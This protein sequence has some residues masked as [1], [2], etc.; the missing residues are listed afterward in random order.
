M[1]ERSFFEKLNRFDERYAPA[2]YEDTDLC[3]SVR[4]AGK[5]VLYQPH[6]IVTHFE[7]VSSG[8]EEDKGIKRFQAIN[9]ESFFE[10]WKD[11]LSDHMPNGVN[12]HIASDPMPQGH[13][14]IVD[15]C[16]PTPDQDSG[17]I[18]MLN[19]IRIVTDLG[20][21]VHFIPYTNFA[22]FGDYT[23]NLQQMGVECIYAPHYRSCDE[24]LREN[25]A[26]FDHVLISRV[27]VADEVMDLVRQRCYGAKIIFY[28]VDLHFLR[29]LRE[30]GLTGDAA[31]AAKARETERKELALMDRADV[32]IVLSEVEQEQLRKRGKSNI[33]VIPLIR[34][35]PKAS[36][37][38][39]E[40]RSGVLFIGGYQH[41]PNIDAVDWL[42]NDIWP[43]VRKLAANNKIAPIPLRL[44][45]SKMPERFRDYACDDIKVHGY[46]GDLT[47]TFAHIRLSVAP[48]RYGAG[49]KGKIATSYEHG[50]PV[51]GTS[52][53]FEGIK[54]EGLDRASYC[55]DS[56]AGIARAIVALYQDPAQWARHSR[57]ARAYAESH[58]SMD[59]ATKRLAAL[60]NSK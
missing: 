22:H 13:I 23:K 16:T 28:T 15:A 24:Y 4:E 12:P 55:A 7:G 45:G 37:N 38:A 19:L 48:L 1:I 21:R 39:F 17:S 52:I 5:R 58:Y 2:Y 60:L 14:L 32:T 51:I 18:D 8:L 50:V 41:T 44:Y 11:R 35:I 26:L 3:F 6:S 30:A 10:K 40:L 34:D 59:N 57:S 46:V 42:V 33:E 27:T 31:L 54:L 53:A 9:K 43:Q 47:D 49:L 36:G 25:S 29:E 56:A 20:Y